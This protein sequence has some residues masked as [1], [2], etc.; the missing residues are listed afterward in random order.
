MAKPAYVLTNQDLALLGEGTKKALTSQLSDGQEVITRAEYEARLSQLQAEV[1]TVVDST[2]ADADMAEAHLPVQVTV[3]AEHYVD[4]KD[5]VLVFDND[6]DDT[7]FLNFKGTTFAYDTEEMQLEASLCKEEG[8]ELKVH[9][10][11]YVVLPDG[12]V[13]YDGHINM[14]VTCVEDNDINYLLLLRRNG[15]SKLFF[16]QE[17]THKQKRQRLVDA[18]SAVCTEYDDSRIKAIVG[19]IISQHHDYVQAEA[20]REAAERKAEEERAQME[21]TNRQKAKD[22]VMSS[23]LTKGAPQEIVDSL[24]ELQFRKLMEEAVNVSKQVKEAIKE[25]KGKAA[26]KKEA[27]KEAP[28]DKAFTHEEE[29]KAKSILLDAALISKVSNNAE[30]WADYVVMLTRI[31]KSKGM[32]SMSLPEMARSIKTL[33]EAFYH[34]AFNSLIGKKAKEMPLVDQVSAVSRD[35]F[36]VEMRTLK[37]TNKQHETAVTQLERAI[38]KSYDFTMGL[39][40]I[41]LCMV[42]NYAGKRLKDQK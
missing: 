12:T 28:K 42:F 22:L 11:R 15:N 34:G 25:H 24:V 30:Y 17:A 8:E 3:E 38:D 16:V 9:T 6:R 41:D 23:P 27:V 36:P 31:D 4:V 10:G 14:M 20:A 39:S 29:M 21:A 18:L 35:I 32:Y 5:G 33:L 19:T 2:D 7:I 26:P 1:E 13:W 40:A 37:H